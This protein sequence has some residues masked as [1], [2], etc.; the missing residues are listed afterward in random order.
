MWSNSVF[1]GI[2][3]SPNIVFD[4]HLF[5]RHLQFTCP[6]CLNFSVQERERA[7]QVLV[8]VCKVAGYYTVTTL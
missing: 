2:G 1:T 3:V 4:N 8:K 5:Y 6:F 7:V